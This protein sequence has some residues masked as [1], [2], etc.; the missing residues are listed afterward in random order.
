M[1]RRNTFYLVIIFLAVVFNVS[2]QDL[3]V[4]IGDV[5]D[6][7]TT[8]EFFAGLEIQL[9]F[10][11]D[12]LDNTESMRCIIK[13]AVDDTGRNLIKENE[14]NQFTDVNKDNPGRADF[15]VNLKN[16]S[17][18]AK[19]VKELSGEIELYIPKND[20]NATVTLK[21]FT[22]QP[23]KPVSHNGLKANNISLSILTTDQYESFKKK[24]KS[25]IDTSGLMGQMVN[26]LSNLFGGFSEPGKNSIIFQVHDP[27]ARILNYNFFDQSG[28]IIESNGSTSSEDIKIIDFEN[29]LPKNA[30]LK[31]FLKTD[32]SIKIIPFN[33]T[34]I[35]LP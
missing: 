21:N 33:L 5:K 25:Q 3:R 28:K 13:N 12:I 15:T 20:P 4:N 35:Y 22:A 30:Q 26:A 10:L 34:D 6:S 8:G 27:E 31:L 9:Q 32:S 11:S 14:D 18:N 23:G 1:K 16:P 2:A 17:R 29:P 7:R 19:T 24:Q